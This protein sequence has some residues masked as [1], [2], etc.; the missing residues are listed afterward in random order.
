VPQSDS[1]P[2][3]GDLVKD[4]TPSKDTTP[5]REVGSAEA[6]GRGLLAG[7]SFK[8]EPSIVGGYQAAKTAIGYGEPGESA[9]QAYERIRQSELEENERALAQHPYLFRAGEFGGTAATSLIPVLGPARAATMAGRIASSMGAGIL[10]GGLSGAGQEV[11]RGSGPE[12]VGRSALLGMGVGGVLGGVGGTAVEGLSHVGSRAASIVRGARDPER[13][14]ARI[15]ADAY[16]SP[17]QQAR[18]EQRLSDQRAIQ[19]GRAAGTPVVLA[20]IGGAPAHAIGR[21]AAN[22]SPEAREMLG[23]FVQNRY[24]QQAPRVANWLR[25]HFGAFDTAADAKRSRVP[26]AKQTPVTIVAPW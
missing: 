4:W 23:E 12:D 16:A 5:E 3:A 24:R 26:R 14:A 9:G 6:A 18:I 8:F 15:V 11:S 19:A 22:I 10:G 17:Q 21:A 7:A 2:T 25:S 13:E 1:V 20:D